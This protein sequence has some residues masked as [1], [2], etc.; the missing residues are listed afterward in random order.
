MLLLKPDVSSEG[1]QVHCFIRELNWIHSAAGFDQRHDLAK[2][3]PAVERDHGIDP[4][5]VEVEG[6]KAAGVDAAADHHLIH[7]VMRPGILQVDVVLIRPE[8]VNCVVGLSCAEHAPRRRGSLLHRILPVLDAHPSLKD[9][10]EVIGDVACR[11]DARRGRPTEFVHDDPVVHLYPGFRGKVCHWLN[12]DAHNGE[13][14]IDAAS[15]RCDD[16]LDPF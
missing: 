13:I 11:V 15:A 14:T 7:R 1:A 8:P 16:P 4:A 9:G 5:V 12:A 6:Q 2:L 10:M 3:F